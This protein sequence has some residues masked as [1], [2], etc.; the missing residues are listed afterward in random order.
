MSIENDQKRC[1]IHFDGCN[2]IIRK[3]AEVDAEESAQPEP[4]EVQEEDEE[5]GMTMRLPHSQK[6]TATRHMAQLFDHRWLYTTL[7][8]GGV[9]DR[10]T[11]KSITQNTR[12]EYT[13][14][15]PL[16]VSESNRASSGFR[17]ADVVWNMENRAEETAHSCECRSW[18]SPDLVHKYVIC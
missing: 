10:E 16:F 3:G 15:T 13:S 9:A 14:D 12:F 17:V 6:S 2:W 18:M 8:H 4:E 5:W 11:C 7:L 1:N